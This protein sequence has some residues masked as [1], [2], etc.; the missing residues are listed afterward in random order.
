MNTAA[1]SNKKCWKIFTESVKKSRLF[2]PGS[3][4][5]VFNYLRRPDSYRIG[6]K[7][8]FTPFA[9]DSMWKMLLRGLMIKEK[10]LIWKSK[11]LLKI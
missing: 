1:A 7:L 6:V 10:M 5:K 4:F 11:C 9:R 8:T 3:N 2:E